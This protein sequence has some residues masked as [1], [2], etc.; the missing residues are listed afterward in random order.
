MW[1][2]NTPYP[3]MDDD[4]EGGFVKFCQ[5][6]EAIVIENSPLRYIGNS[7]RW[8]SKELKLLVVEKKALHR[9]FKCTHRE[10]DYL[11]FSGLRRRCKEL[12][13]QCH[14]LYMNHIKQ[15]FQRT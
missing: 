11:R 7:P 13:N 12:A 2:Q 6:L 4:V 1:I 10:E 5:S 9:I 15:Q 3:L 8:F 14:S